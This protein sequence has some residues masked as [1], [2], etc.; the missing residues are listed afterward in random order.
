MRRVESFQ[1][2]R[3]KRRKAGRVLRAVVVAFLALELINGL[4]VKSWVAASGSMEPTIEPGDRVL[5]TRAGYGLP[6][7]FGTGRTAFTPPERGDV[8]LMREPAS[9]GLSFPARILDG[10]LRF[11]SAQRLGLDRS[12]PVIK[13]VVGLP[14]DVVKMENFIVY[15]RTPGT[16]HFLTEYEVSGKAYDLRQRTARGLGRRLAPVRI[17]PGD[18]PVGRAVLR[19]GRRPARVHRFPVLRPHRR[20]PHRGQGLG[21]LLAVQPH[22]PILAWTPTAAPIAATIRP[23][24]GRRSTCTYRSAF[25]AA[26]TA[27][28]TAAAWRAAGWKPGWKP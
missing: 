8:I 13:R 16:M 3:A 6:V 18:L 2:A 22:G 1:N 25:P 28:S 17:L 11:F 12:P 5:V 4:I 7:P 10:V 24:P 20:R 23:S 27:I 14:G 26:P 19:G 9:D 15:V 21:A